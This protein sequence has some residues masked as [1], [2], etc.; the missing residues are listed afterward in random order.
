MRLRPRPCE[1]ESTEQSPVKRKALEKVISHSKLRHY[2]SQKLHAIASAD[3]WKE[4]PGPSSRSQ[5]AHDL[6]F[7]QKNLATCQAADSTV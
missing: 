3:V 7:F 6:V 5:T 1:E 2:Q 4:D